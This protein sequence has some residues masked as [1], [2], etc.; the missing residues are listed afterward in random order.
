MEVI[1]TNVNDKKILYRMTASTANREKLQTISKG[2]IHVESYCLFEREDDNGEIT[3]VLSLIVNGTVY[4][5]ISKT[6]IRSFD[7]ILTAF[8]EFS[9]VV[10]DVGTSRNGRNYLMFRI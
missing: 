1:S 5:T 9:D 10:L 7:E 2:N 8:G 3:K 4:S 6:A